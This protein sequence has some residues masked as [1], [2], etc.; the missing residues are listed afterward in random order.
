M[1]PALI[2]VRRVL[3]TRGRHCPGRPGQSPRPV[4]EIALVS[5]APH[6]WSQLVPAPGWEEGPRT[7]AHR[8]LGG[9]PRPG[10]AP[11]PSSRTHPPALPPASPSFLVPGPEP[12]NCSPLQN[13][14]HSII[15]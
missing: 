15:Y 8:A 9:T 7:A 2:E 11:G 13:R 6:T 1:G 10:P 12:S 3:G 14:F 5:S 4:W